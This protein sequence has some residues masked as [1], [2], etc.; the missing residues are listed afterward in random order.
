MGKT[1]CKVAKPFSEGLYT[2]TNSTNIY[3]PNELGIELTSDYLTA[4]PI[5]IGHTSPSLSLTQAADNLSMLNHLTITNTLTQPPEKPTSR[6]CVGRPIGAVDSKPRQSKGSKHKSVKIR[7]VHEIETISP[8]KKRKLTEIIGSPSSSNT[9]DLSLESCYKPIPPPIDTS[10]LG[11]PAAAPYIWELLQ[12]PE[13]ANFFLQQG[14]LNLA[15]APA[16]NL[17]NSIDSPTSALRLP[18]YNEIVDPLPICYDNIHR[19][20]STTLNTFNYTHNNNLHQASSVVAQLHGSQ[21]INNNTLGI[22]N[23]NF[24][25]SLAASAT[26]FEELGTRS[27]GVLGAIQWYLGKGF[28][29]IE[30]ETDNTEAAN[31]LRGVQTNLS[32]CSS[33][34][35]DNVINLLCSFHIISFK[36]C[37]RD[38]NWAAHLLASHANLSS[39]DTIS[40]TAAPAW[41]C[42]QFASDLLFCNVLTQET[43]ETFADV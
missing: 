5:Q 16:M 19:L 6:R 34:I 24:G 30:L 12:L 43:E 20:T 4:T 25:L 8:T 38:G 40:Y 36:H 3:D 26:Y 10:K 21:F 17:N 31:Y 39:L 41:L 11:Y 23:P 22:I 42:S 28:K 18:F 29:R 9:Q 15:L 14:V 32:W 1:S 27:R 33:S 37:N 7:S 35:L 2:D 13:I